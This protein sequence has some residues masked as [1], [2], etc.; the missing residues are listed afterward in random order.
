MCNIFL[1]KNTNN[2]I[3]EVTLIITISIPE[4][5]MANQTIIVAIVIGVLLISVLIIFLIKQASGRD[6][7]TYYRQTKGQAM[8]TGIAIGMSIGT[9]FG[10]VFGILIDNIALGISI[11]P[12]MGL[13][14]GTAIGA[15]MQKKQ[16]ENIRIEEQPV[17]KPAGFFVIALTLAALV[18]GLLVFF[19]IAK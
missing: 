12:G 10:V 6:H 2:V 7:V 13:A 8:G 16:G 18:A 15:S 1:F 3:Y 11:G 19:L 9:A 4:V 17:R 14:I 5:Q